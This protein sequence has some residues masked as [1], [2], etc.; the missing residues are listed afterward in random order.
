MVE[1]LVFGRSGLN[2]SVFEKLFISYSCISFIKQCSLRS[3]CIKMLCF[4]KF[5]FFQIFNQSNLLLDWL[6]KIFGHN[7]PGSK[8]LKFD[9][10][11]FKNFRL[12]KFSKISK[13]QLGKIW[14]SRAWKFKKLG[15][16]FNWA[17]IDEIDLCYWLIMSLYDVI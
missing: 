8:N 16:L 12:G 17:K 1:K 4:S 11:N 13:F 14:N 10:E 3:F 7:L 5:W 2:S 15:I 6:G 9:Q